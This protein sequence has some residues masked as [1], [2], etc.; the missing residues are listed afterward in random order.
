M[1]TGDEF[2]RETSGQA[3][4]LLDIVPGARGEGI[5]AQIKRELSGQSLGQKMNV[6]TNVA[7]TWY[8]DEG[9]RMV[10]RSTNNALAS[11]SN[12]VSNVFDKGIK[13][14]TMM[15]VL[16]KRGKD[17]KFDDVYKEVSKALLNYQSKEFSQFERQVLK[18]IFPFYGFMSRSVAMVAGEL[19]TNPGGR[20]AQTI[21]A[22]RHMQ[23]SEG[24]TP[25]ELQDT[26]AVP[27]GKDAENNLRFLTGFGLMHE[28]AMQYLAPTQGY[29]GL[30]QKLLGSANPVLKQPIEYALNTSTFFEGPMGGRRLDDL[31]PTMGRLK[32]LIGERIGLLDPLKPGQ[33]PKPIGGSVTESMVASS[34]AAAWLR[35]AR[36][37][38]DPRKGTTEKL[39]NI[40][41]GVRTK[42]MSPEAQ[43]REI[44]DRI[45][46][47]EIELGARPL[48]LTVGNKKL[49]ERA[50]AEGDLVKA[51]RLKAARK[52][53]EHIRK[54]SEK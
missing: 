5:G 17:V 13:L 39:A 16:E 14:G 27:L 48:T 22:Q 15:A 46:A 25:Y 41:T 29:R 2:A 6:V 36:T 7:G 43:I 10:Q 40:F 50:R 34:P 44:R 1:L 23:D 45:N 31:D 3:D 53:L 42:T 54:A 11:I 9:G 49:E 21:R 24:Y 12:R 26:A 38:L 35:I 28:D 37:S 32:Q 8:R 4:R 20:L 52:V 19:A 47:V 51:D 30:L 33:S 18:R